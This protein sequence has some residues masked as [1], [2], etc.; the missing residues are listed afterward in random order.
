MSLLSRLIVKTAF[1]LPRGGHHLVRL[2]SGIV[3]GLRKFPRKLEPFDYTMICD[4]SEVVFYPLAKHGRYPHA[5]GEEWSWRGSQDRTGWCSMLV[6]ISDLRQQC[7]PA[8]ARRG[9]YMRLNQLLCA[10]PHLK[11]VAKDLANF[12]ILTTA[13]G[14]CVGSVRF[15]ERSS[16]DLSAV[17][18]AGEL[19]V[20]MTTLDLW[21]AGRNVRPSFIKIDVEGLDKEVLSGANRLLSEVRPIVMFEATK[22]RRLHQH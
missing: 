19:E 6:P 11:R 14:S 1:S 18:P 8:C 15:T 16:L 21:C 17:V 4:L 7:W 10:R 2:A 12:E 20:P 9:A 5:I 22:G 3:P 13:I